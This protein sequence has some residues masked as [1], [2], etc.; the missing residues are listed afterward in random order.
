MS[1]LSAPL[2]PLFTSSMSAGDPHMMNTANT[3]TVNQQLQ[4]M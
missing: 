1:L 3:E 2:I 4:C